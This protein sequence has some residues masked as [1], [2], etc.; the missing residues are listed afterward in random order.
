MKFFDSIAKRFGYV[1]PQRRNFKAAAA[2]RLLSDWQKSPSSADAV[3]KYDLKTL[4][5]RARDLE[6]NNDYVRKF[7]SILDNNILGPKGVEL[8]MRT[9]DRNGDLDRQANDIIETAWK[10]WSRAQLHG[11]AL[12]NVARRSTPRLA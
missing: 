8:E 6:A 12:A 1:K 5:S 3:L 10:N 11:H 4:R 7:L 2:S 9:K